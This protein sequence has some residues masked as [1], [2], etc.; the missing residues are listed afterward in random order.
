ME[1]KYLRF[2]IDQTSHSSFFRYARN[3][4]ETR[5]EINAT[6]GGQD[7]ELQFGSC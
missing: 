6:A 4:A 5:S 7:W 3:Q 1:R 2:F